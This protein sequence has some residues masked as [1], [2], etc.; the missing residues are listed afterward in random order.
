MRKQGNSHAKFV[1]KKDID[2]ARLAGDW[3]LHATND[4]DFTI[5]PTACWH[6]HMNVLPDG[7]FIAKQEEKQL[8]KDW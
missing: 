5:I 2:A 3:Y 7:S 6:L 8:N 4:I 1:F